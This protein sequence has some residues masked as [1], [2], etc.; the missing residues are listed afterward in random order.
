MKIFFKLLA[1]L[2]III[3]LVISC[4]VI[5]LRTDNAQRIVTK[6]ISTYLKDNLAL[7]VDFK[8]IHI[9]FPFKLNIES[10]NVSDH[11]GIVGDISNLEINAILAPSIF[12]EIN[13]SSIKA[14]QL[15][16][17]KYPV[18]KTIK[19]DDSDKKSSVF[20]PNI[21]IDEINIKEINLGS[22]ITGASEVTSFNLKTNINFQTKEKIIEYN[23]L[24]NL[25]LPTDDLLEDSKLELTG[26]YNIQDQKL[27]VKLIKFSS[28]GI[29]FNGNLSIDNQLKD[30]FGEFLYQSNILGKLLN[31]KWP[32]SQADI[33]GKLI[34][35]GKLTQP[36]INIKGS[37]SIDHP[38]NI[39][40]EILPLVYIGQFNVDEHSNIF[41]N[42]NLNYD[43]IDINGEISYAQNKLNLKKFIITG[44]DLKG[45]LNAELDFQTYLL[46]G[47]FNLKDETLSEFTKYFPQIHSGIVDLSADFSANNNKQQ[48]SLAGKIDNFNYDSYSIDLLSFN[49]KSPDIIAKT[50]S[51]S[52]ILVHTLNI[53]GFILNEINIKAQSIKDQ[54]IINTNV[55]SRDSFPFNIRA[56]S[57]LQILDDG[58]IKLDID[59]LSGKIDKSK[60]QNTKKLSLYYGDK[61]SFDIDKL[62]IDNGNIS[63]GGDLS[64]EKIAA[65]LNI[66]N[67]STKMFDDILSEQFINSIIN[68]NIILSGTASKPILTSDI[69]IT[70]ILSIENDKKFSIKLN[71][72]TNNNQ[73]DFSA[74][75]NLSLKKIA[76]I[77]GLIKNSFSLLPFQFMIN[78]NQDLQIDINLT[79]QFNILSLLPSFPGQKIE[80]NLNGHVKVS[81][82]PAVPIIKG[83]L[84][85]LEGK[86]VYKNLGVKFKN[87]TSDIV[88]NGY[89]ITFSD[90][91]GQDIFNNNI[92]GSGNMD[93][94]NFNYF[95]ELHTKK[96]NPINTPYIHGDIN[97]DIT[98]KGDLNSAIAT[99]QFALGPM[100]I[101]IPERYH[102]NIPEL[103]IV[104]INEGN[105][106]DKN[107]KKPYDFMLKVNL[108]TNDKVYVRGWGVDTRLDGNLKVSG[109][110]ND[111][112]VKGTLQ[113]VKGRYKEF[114]KVLSIKEGILSF[115]GPIMPSPYL[116]IVGETNVS[117]NLIRVILAGTIANPEIRLESTPD[118]PEE[119]ALSILL[120]GTDTENISAFQA[121]Q[122]ADSARRLSGKGGGFDPLS[123]GRKIL[124]VDDINFKT[125]A[126]NP[127]KVSVGVGKYLTDKIYFEIEQGQQSGATKTRVEIQISPTVSIEN[128]IE[129]QGNTSLGIN[130]RFDY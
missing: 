1:F 94:K 74:N 90:I 71:S 56:D 83:N 118:M 122:L 58:A 65:H 85:L 18:I 78:D 121:V 112:K 31:D 42:I 35:S 99:G 6:K 103:N 92:N 70:D 13:I 128:I 45:S 23:L 29:D 44:T 81:G 84:K 14:K 117:G 63:L 33:D 16:L 107:K 91:E 125:D 59:Q 30:I 3:F 12:K 43:S 100:E 106:E 66:N 80:G 111:P 37:L 86:Y 72:T 48:I 105:V 96:F 75:A 129:Q 69:N 127:D 10:I 114:G 36:N 54:I 97:G 98:I 20:N 116:N 26:L 53:D 124:G 40:N 110:I 120:F 87:I 34:I 126:D 2:L 79:D 115:D 109:N 28:T 68:G 130:W 21:I 101:K 25:L 104:E 7:N 89:K 24:S 11:D 27:N 38:Y 15:N 8:N 50:L 119:R 32:N 17:L 108:K 77:D 51:D 64:L 113:T 22:K 61:I 76:S 47:S 102:T 123:M 67:F 46:N 73:T 9:S 95:F 5:W 62:Q 93:L 39:S 49:I 52:N 19:T 60:I 57:V 82:T 4:G 55:I 88:A 41:G